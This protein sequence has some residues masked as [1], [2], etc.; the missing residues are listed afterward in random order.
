M[1][2]SGVALRVPSRRAP[3]T[4]TRRLSSFMSTSSH[5]SSSSAAAVT[6]P[7][8]LVTPGWVMQRLGQP[9]LKVLDASWYP[10]NMPPR[11]TAAEHASK[12]IPGAAFFG[13]DDVCDP[14]S[15]LPHMLPPEAVMDAYCSRV[16]IGAG[17]AVVVY[18]SFGILSSAR[19]WWTFR[20][21]GHENVAVLNGGLPAWE[22]EGGTLESGPLPSGSETGLLKADSPFRASRVDALVRSMAQVK[23]NIEAKGEVLL[24]ARPAPRFSGEA[25]EPRPTIL[26]GHIPGSLNVPFTTLLDEAKRM[27]PAEE[28]AQAF[29]AGGLGDPGVPVAISCGS[30]ATACILSLA[31]HVLGNESAAVYDGSW[32]EWG[33]DPS[34]PVAKGSA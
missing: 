4:F 14:G 32:S 3:L 16:G 11:D 19:V 7:G 18:D 17:D 29:R 30:G 15:R 12:R 31:L 9:G 28:L 5:P 10:P 24:D 1:L 20:A 25:P 22:A 26:S 6:V 13:L 21:L 34:A 23:A 27:K 33:N 2:L 8:P